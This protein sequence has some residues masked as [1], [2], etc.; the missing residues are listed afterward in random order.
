[1]NTM[2][3]RFAHT[4]LLLAMSMIPVLAAA[5]PGVVL[6]NFRPYDQHGVSMFEPPKEE[7]DYDS[8]FKLGVG[9]TQQFQML[10]HENTADP[11]LNPDGVNLNELKEIGAGFNLAT[12]NLNLDAMLAEGIRVNLITYLSS[13]HHAEAWVKGGYLQ[14]DE[15]PMLNSETIDNLFDYVT[16]RV[17]HMEINYGDGHFRRSDN[18]NAMYNPFVGNYIMDSFTTEIG[19]ELYVQSNGFLGM[20]GV[21]DGEIRGRVDLPDERSPSIYGKVGFDRQVN[22]DLRVRLTGSALTTSSS[23]SNTLFG[24]DRGGSRYYEVTENT[25]S[26]TS[27][28]FT[29][30]RINPGF[31]DEVTTFQINPFVQ[32]NGIELF[33]LFEQ[34]SGRAQNETENR[35][36]TQ[37]AVEG[38]FRFLDRDQAYVGARYN[39]VS[40]ELPG[41]G[42]EVSVNRVQVGG[43]WFI[44]PS[45]LLKGE[46]VMQSY[47]DYP[48]TSIFN[49]AEFSGVIFEGVIAF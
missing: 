1:M 23:A 14:I 11:V 15:M 7:G 32:Y 16:L 5:Q 43:G 3:Q 8:R 6:P 42:M 31:R 38:I 49:G 37:L 34:A 40:G 2:S 21:T 12:A 22:D 48:S 33:G 45:I 18:G 9:F 4:A 25:L 39:T 35:T 24:G 19:G 17:G 41:S 13:R 46:Y 20:L 26:S 36:W 28:N 47:N 30:G 10:D 27:S 29:S 44:V